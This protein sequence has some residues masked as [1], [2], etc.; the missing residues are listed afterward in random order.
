MRHGRLFWVL[1]KQHIHILLKTSYYWDVHNARG[2]NV[3]HS[4]FLNSNITLINW[5]INCWNYFHHFGIKSKISNKTPRKYNKCRVTFRFGVKKKSI[6]TEILRKT[7]LFKSLPS[8]KC[9]N[10]DKQQNSVLKTIE[11][12]VTFRINWFYHQM[13]GG[14]FLTDYLQSM[15]DLID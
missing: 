8:F 6:N 4:L 7:V 2:L 15:T 11:S 14:S 13:T 12:A 10:G 1:R 3:S 9:Q 5:N